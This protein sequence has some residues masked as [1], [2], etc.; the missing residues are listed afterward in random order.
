VSDVVDA[1]VAE[2][3]KLRIENAALKAAGNRSP[4]H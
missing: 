3:K 2:I 1:A 4:S